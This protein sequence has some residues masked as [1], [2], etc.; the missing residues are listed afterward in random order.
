MKVFCMLKKELLIFSILFLFLALGMHMNQ[1]M[2]HPLEHLRHLATHKMP[3][4]PL[5]Y[6][7]LLYIFVGVLRGFW[8]IL[9]KIFSKS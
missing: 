1:W 8:L 2:S 4:H 7:L 5:L 3:Y 9:K 6:T